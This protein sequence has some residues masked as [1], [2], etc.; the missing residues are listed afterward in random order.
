MPPVVNTC[1]ETASNVV[2]IQCVFDFLTPGHKEN[3]SFF[4]SAESVI[5]Y[6]SVLVTVSNR[7]TPITDSLVKLTQR[8]RRGV[9]YKKVKKIKKNKKINGSV[10]GDNAKDRRI[11]NNLSVIDEKECI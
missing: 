6:C 7:L 5:T 2:L 9:F 3:Y 11:S 10:S 4:L 1:S 8:G